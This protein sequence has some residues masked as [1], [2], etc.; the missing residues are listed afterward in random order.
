MDDILSWLQV[1]SPS[2]SPAPSDLHLPVFPGTLS[3][4]T[5]LQD[6]LFDLL[7][8]PLDPTP[9]APVSPALR[10]VKRSPSAAPSRSVSPTG[11]VTKRPAPKR[12]TVSS[13]LVIGRP[14]GRPRKTAE[15]RKTPPAFGFVNVV[16]DQPCD[17][18][19]TPCHR[20][21]LEA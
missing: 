6:P 4:I 21:V 12:S 5:A 11:R 19:E 17:A 18:G 14:R 16:F 1:S 10:T 2:P 8:I 13:G 20:E 3:P 7:N 9:V 15:T